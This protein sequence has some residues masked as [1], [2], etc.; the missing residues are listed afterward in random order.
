MPHLKLD[1]KFELP[2][3]NGE[4]DAEKLDNWIRQIE[5]YCRIQ[6]FTE[7]DVKIQLASFRL[8]GTARIWWESR[9]REDL[10]TKGKIISSWYEFISA[11]KKK[12]YPLGYMQQAMMDWKNLRQGKG[13][14]VQ[15]YTQEFW[16]R[17]LV[18]GIPLY[19]QE[20]LLKYIGGLHNYLR[21]MIL[22][23]NPTNLDE[24]S[25]QETH[26]ESKGKS[27]HDVYSAESV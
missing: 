24:V 4:L 17:A 26:I 6:K 22:M 7:D 3:Y 2:M 25:V 27:V 10:A 11:L 21:H 5:V 15:E 8:G 16:K 19:T 20:N 23:F 9:S 18:L 13:Q 12:F 14:S 1:I